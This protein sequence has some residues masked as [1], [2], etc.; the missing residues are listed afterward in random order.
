MKKQIILIGL[1]IHLIGLSEAAARSYE[2]VTTL[3]NSK[4]TKPINGSKELIK[5]LFKNERSNTEQIFWEGRCYPKGHQFYFTN[6]QKK[7]T[8]SLKDYDVLLETRAIIINYGL[9]FGGQ[10]RYPDLNFLKIYPSTFS[11]NDSLDDP[12]WDS[13]RDDTDP[14]YSFGMSSHGELGKQILITAVLTKS[15]SSKSQI[16]DTETHVKK[17]A[18]SFWKHPTAF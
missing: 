13:Y 5:I 7:M 15:Y 9:V 17:E 16:T 2:D 18:C 3:H 10:E 12:W 8:T 4:K 14:R 11:S 1:L 6:G